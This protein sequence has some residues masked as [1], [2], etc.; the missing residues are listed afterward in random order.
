M[1]AESVREPAPV[2]AMEPVPER[3]PL[4]VAEPVV[5]ASVVGEAGAV[6]S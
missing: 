6:V 3:T 4:C 1:A 5:R 2:F